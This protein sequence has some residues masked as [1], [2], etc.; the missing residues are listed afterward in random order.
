MERKT[1]FLLLLGIILLIG[2]ERISD[3]IMNDKQ[4]VKL[5]DTCGGHNQKQWKL[6]HTTT[7]VFNKPE[8]IVFENAL[9][10][11]TCP[12][13]REDQQAGHSYF[14][15]VHDVWL[16]VTSSEYGDYTYFIDSIR[17]P[18]ARIEIE[19]NTPEEVRLAFIYS[20]KNYRARTGATWPYQG[21]MH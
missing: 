5:Y 15:N 7:H 17:M 2:I 9:F 10:R 19:K 20:H 12:I 3:F 11:V 8:Q 13:L 18:P 6:I 16:P 21:E 14:A 1:I 4:D